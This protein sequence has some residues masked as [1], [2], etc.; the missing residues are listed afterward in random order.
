MG[1]LSSSLRRIAEDLRRSPLFGPKHSET[2]L[3]AA[4]A[5]ER[6]GWVKC[7]ERLPEQD[8]PVLAWVGE[9]D[10]ETHPFIVKTVPTNRPPTHRVGWAAISNYQDGGVDSYVWGVTHWVPPPPEAPDGV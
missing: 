8:A 7:S 1:D 5:L 9:G 3:D 2:I 4:T 6:A 10:G